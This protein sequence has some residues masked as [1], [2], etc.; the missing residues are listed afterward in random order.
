MKETDALRVVDL[1]TVAIIKFR[2]TVAESVGLEEEAREIFPHLY[3]DNS[4]LKVLIG[5]GDRRT[6]TPL[7]LNN[8]LMMADL[9]PELSTMYISL[10]EELLPAIDYTQREWDDE[11]A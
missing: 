8:I 5:I 7:D 6:L 4:L 3:G 1:L 11:Q 2:S 10:H 9:H